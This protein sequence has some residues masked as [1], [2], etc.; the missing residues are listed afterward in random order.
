MDNGYSVAAFEIVVSKDNEKP[1]ASYMGY[2]IDGLLSCDH[3]DIR[4]SKEWLGRVSVGW[5]VGWL[6]ATAHSRMCTLRSVAM[7]A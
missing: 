3:Q 5:L 1:Q 2:Q 7:S 6:V 4:I